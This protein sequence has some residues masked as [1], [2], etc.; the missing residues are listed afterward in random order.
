MGENCS[1]IQVEDSGGKDEVLGYMEGS[2]YTLLTSMA[3]VVKE[4]AQ[5]FF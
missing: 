2:F 5:T 1:K 3:E 4:K